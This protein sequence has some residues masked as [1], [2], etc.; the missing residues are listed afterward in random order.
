MEDDISPVD[1]EY[2]HKGLKVYDLVYNRATP[3]VKEALAS[4]LR[5]TNGLNMLLY[6]GAASFNHWT[7]REAPLEIMRQALNEGVKKI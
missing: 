6:Q 3:L 7:G 2:L 5:A 4:G 1:K